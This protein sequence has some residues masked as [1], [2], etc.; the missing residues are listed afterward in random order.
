MI[1]PD[2]K[3]IRRHL[4]DILYIWL[5]LSLILPNVMLSV[6]ETMTVWGSVANVMLPLGIIAWAAALSPKIGRTVWL[7]FPLILIAAFQIVLLGLYGRSVIAVDM[8][9]NVLTTNPSEV[10]ELLGNLWPSVLL[11]CVLYLP[12]LVTAVVLMRSRRLLSPRFAGV[13]RRVSGAVAIAGAVVLGICYTTDDAY[14]VRNDLYPVNAGYNVCLAVDRT[15]RT[16]R[17][18]DT[19]RA[20][21]YDA[22][23]TAPDSIRAL[24][25]VVV[26]ETSR[27]ADWQLLGYSRP[28]N[29]RLSRR[30]EGLYV[31]PQAYSESNTTHKSVPMLLSPVDAQTFG[32]D[33]Y[34]TKSL[35]TAFK[36]AGYETA[37]ISNQRPN[38]SFIDFFGYEADTTEFVREQTGYVELPGDFNLL[39]EVSRIIGDS[40]RRQLIVLHTYG[41]HFDYRDRYGDEDRHFVP[42]TYPE[43]SASYRDELV[44]AYDNTIVATDRFLDSLM[45]LLEESG[46]SASLIY[47]SDHGEDIY[48][49]GSR[50]FLHASPLPSVDQVH[51]PMLVWLSPVYMASHPQ[52][53]GILRANSGRLVSTSRSFCPTALTLGDVATPRVDP[54]ASL[55]S[56]SYAGRAPLY[57]TDHN[58]PV[59]LK[60]ILK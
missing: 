31:S 52:A 40:A 22:R 23:F 11:V 32:K 41:S 38:H 54:S 39:A 25:V 1:R 26:G 42:D 36:E 4:P 16:G 49:H 60:D 6:T 35:I 14:A 43:A 21:T 19:S 12:V 48:D 27:A 37:F 47:A 10:G 17:Y 45:G 59:A 53:D 18:H 29:P 5:V 56:G 2:M 7:M 44:N 9:L 55:A 24:M 3:R 33:I 13:C 28:T 30:S 51:V 15:L 58:E 8:F 57:L 34:T 50:G 20:Y 46:A